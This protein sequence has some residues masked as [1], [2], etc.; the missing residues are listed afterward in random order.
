MQSGE[1]VRKGDQLTEGPLNPHDI[2]RLRGR[3]ELQQYIVSEVQR[4]YRMVGVA[5][6]DKH[7]EIIIRQMLRHDRVRTPGDT[8]FLPEDLVDRAKLA[9]ANEQ[10]VETG[11]RPAEAQEVLLGVT[12]ASLSSDSFLA[13]ASFQ[14]TTRVLTEAVVEGKHDYLHGLKENVI[15]GKLIP[16]GTGWDKYHGPALEA[17][18][19]SDVLIDTEAMHMAEGVSLDD[20]REAADDA[21]GAPEFKDGAQAGVLAAGA[22]PMDAAEKC[23]AGGNRDV[24]N[25]RQRRVRRFSASRRG[26]RC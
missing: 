19:Q 1:F 12:K 7:V 5:V 11:G 8:Q 16:A 22:P 20:L 9:E 13:A 2:L 10:I 17:P 25:G 23:I 4:V 6:N 18:A 15:I 3:P 21:D 26:P 14:D 24:L